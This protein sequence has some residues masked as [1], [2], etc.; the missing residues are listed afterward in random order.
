[1]LPKGRGSSNRGVAKLGKVDLESI[2]CNATGLFQSCN[3]FADIQVHPSIECELAE[4]VLVDDFFRNYVQ[5]DLYILIS[6]HRGI[7][8]ETFNIQSKET[9]T[10]GGDG[11]VQKALSCCQDDTVGCGAARELQLFCR[12]R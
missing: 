3:A 12:R 7:V 2:V 6:R 9:G 4:V 10:G 11:A 8:I 5:A 1:M